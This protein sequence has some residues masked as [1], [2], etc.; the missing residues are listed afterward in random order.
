MIKTTIQK[1]QKYQA[2][3]MVEMLIVMAIIIMLFAM[4]MT[5][6]SGMQDSITLTDS[7]YSFE[8]DVHY[9]QRSSLF[10]KREP[11]E[12]WIYGI[13]I[14][15]SGLSVDGT[16]KLFKWCSP[17]NDF[18][19]NAEYSDGT[20]DTRMISE[21]PSFE[22]LKNL[23]VDY[24]GKKNGSIATSY[25]SSTDYCGKCVVND[26][27]SNEELIRMNDFGDTRIG[28]N[29]TVSYLDN[30]NAVI[31]PS[32]TSSTY[33]LFESVTGRAFVYG[34]NG[35]L[36]NYYQDSTGIHLNSGINDLNIK[37]S[38]GTGQSRIIKIKPVSGTVK[39]I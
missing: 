33:L 9:A 23:N 29:I 10:L 38:T 34:A 5:S 13:G 30:N 2:F 12:R 3:T 14:D 36:Q 8:Q 19:S 26:C 11:N 25:T 15:L 35:L 16:Y 1:I 31:V 6:F 20:K 7:S 21:F 32:A 27:R 22:S 39:V 28:S 18:D 17:F 24:L 37:F 4:V